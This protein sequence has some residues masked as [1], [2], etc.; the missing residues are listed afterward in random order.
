MALEA[1]RTLGAQARLRGG[2]SLQAVEQATDTQ[3]TLIKKRM[4]DDRA[5]TARLKDTADKMQDAIK[6]GDIN[7]VGILSADFQSAAAAADANSKDLAQVMMG[8][9]NQF[10]DI[11]IV[12]K[13]VQERSADEQKLVD[14][15]EAFVGRMEGRLAAAN[16]QL[17]TAEAMKLNLFGSKDKAVQAAQDAITKANTDIDNAKAAVLTA[18]QLADQ[19]MRDRLQNMNLEQSLQKLQSTT[20]QIVEIAKARIDE[21]TANLEAIE[22][23]RIQT[24]EDLKAYSA[25]VENSDKDIADLKAELANLAGQQQEHT[26]NTPEWTALNGQIIQ[27]NNDLAELESARNQAFALSQDGARFLEMYKVQESAQRSLLQFHQIWITTLETGVE[28]RSIIYESHLGVIRATGDQQAMGLVDSVAVET[29][30]RITEDATKHL[31]AGRN[32]LQEK[33]ESL[34]EDIKRMRQLTAAEV[35]SAA[36]FEAGLEKLR[37][38]AAHNWNTPQGYDDRATYMPGATTAAP[39]QSAA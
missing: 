7:E 38:L 14:D 3:A 2:V 36:T 25:K 15:A 13:E 19:R 26:E 16:T 27:K 17:A 32:A 6:R 23:G 24:V 20:T 5:R 39:S 11:G 9:G 29:D 33:L 8:L 4:E 34:P 35:Q 21:I 31:A 30:E 28:Q 10:K 1:S 37:D 18:N 22:S 12:L